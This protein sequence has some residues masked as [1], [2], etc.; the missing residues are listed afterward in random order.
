MYWNFFSKKETIK[1]TALVGIKAVVVVLKNSI[2]VFDRVNLF[3]GFY[4]MQKNDLVKKFIIFRKL[5]HWL[6]PIQFQGLTLNL[7]KLSFESFSERRSR[8]R[9]V[10]LFAKRL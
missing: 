9:K 10:P 4:L 6:K 5:R 7:N 8:G 3:V 2:K 1:V